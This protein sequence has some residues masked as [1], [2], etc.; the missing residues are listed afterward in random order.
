MFNLKDRVNHSTF[1]NMTFHYHIVI[2][3]KIKIK[4]ENTVFL[5]VKLLPAL[6][7]YKKI[8]TTLEVSESQ[9]KFT[10]YI[11]YHFQCYVYI[12]FIQ[13]KLSA[14]CAVQCMMDTCS[15]SAAFP[16]KVLVEY[17]TCN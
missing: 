3:A 17:F 7:N 9:F 2:Y 12:T 4:Q 5:P 6:I 10:Y 14:Q 16:F 1:V 8:V 15:T 11:Y 13:N